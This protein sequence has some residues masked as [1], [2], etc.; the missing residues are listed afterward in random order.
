[1]TPTMF[2]VDLKYKDDSTKTV[3]LRTV[4]RNSRYLCCLYQCFALIMS[5]V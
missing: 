4:L 2:V 1:M 5:I 3:T